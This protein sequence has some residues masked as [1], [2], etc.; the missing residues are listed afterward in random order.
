MELTRGE[1]I[2]HL[3]KFASE[4]PEY[5]KALVKDPKSIVA[6][7]FA[8]DIPE[9]VTLKVIEDTADTVH[10]VLPHVVEADEELSDAD[11]EA[12]A[13]GCTGGSSGGTFVKD[14]TCQSGA[15]N[16]VVSVE[17]GL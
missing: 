17:A 6:K 16:T 4:N 3:A 14:A 9:N 5:R 12:V 15:L 10:I 8:M 7:Q 1:I 2:D 11:L 13:G